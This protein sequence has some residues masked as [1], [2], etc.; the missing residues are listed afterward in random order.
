MPPIFHIVPRSD[1]LQ[2][3][4]VGLYAPASLRTQGFIHFST[5][6]QVTRVA[7]FLYAGQFDLLLLEVDADEVA[8]ALK[9]ENLDGNEELFPHLYS[10]LDPMLVKRTYPFPPSADGTFILPDELRA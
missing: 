1:W 9:H 6:E 8:T 4:Q 5:R 10:G 7:D 2:A 3:Q